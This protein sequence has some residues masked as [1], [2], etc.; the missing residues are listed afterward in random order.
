MNPSDNS[1]GSFGE[2]LES[3]REG[4]S[5]MAKKTGGI[6]VWKRANISI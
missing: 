3:I 2:A 1:G 6:E 5:E 4:G